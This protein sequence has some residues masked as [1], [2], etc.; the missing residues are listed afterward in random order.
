[1]PFPS[2][3]NT[4]PLVPSVI[5]KSVIVVG[6]VGLLVKSLYDP[7][8]VD[9]RSPLVSV[10]SEISVGTASVIPKPAS[11]FGVSM[12]LSHE[13]PIF[14]KSTKLPPEICRISPFSVSLWLSVFAA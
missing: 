4:C 11:V 5:P 7:E 2:V 1:M 8:K 3:V 9:A 6:I 12:M 14:D 13:T 10:K